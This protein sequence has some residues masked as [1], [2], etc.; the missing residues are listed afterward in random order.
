LAIDTTEVPARKTSGRAARVLAAARARPGLLLTALYFVIAAA[1]M[2]RYGMWMTPEKLVIVGFAIALLFAKPIAYL[3]DWTPVILLLLGYE[4]L[5]GIAY[6]HGLPVNIHF[7]I[8]ADRFLFLG[9]LPPVALQ[10][11]LLDEGGPLWYDYLAT[12]LYM[13]HTILP[14]GFAYYLWSTRREQFKRFTVTLLVLSYAGFLTYLLYPAMPPW[15]AARDGYIPEVHSVIGRV[16]GHLGNGP[17]LP[18]IYDFANPN[19]VA[20]MPSLHAAYPFLVFLFLL[21]LYGRRA[22]PFVL[23]PL[24][25]WFSIVYTGNHY[26]IDAIAGVAYAL[27]AYYG[28]EWWWKR[29]EARVRAQADAPGPPAAPTPIGG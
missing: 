18:S 16:L 23:Y 19:P 9:K 13:S 2:V 1:L 21:K 5:R 20:A 7:M 29:R 6:T 17:S 8:D 22:L 26:V 24:A 4:F 15:M 14:F 12:L 10:D 28:L 3:R 27:A 11:W 25:V